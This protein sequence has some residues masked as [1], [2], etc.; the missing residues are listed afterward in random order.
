MTWMFD[1]QHFSSVLFSY[2]PSFDAGWDGVLGSSSSSTRVLPSFSTRAPLFVWPVFPS[3]HRISKLAIHI[4]LHLDRVHSLATS[5]VR[6]LPMNIGSFYS[7]PT[8]I[9][10]DIIIMSYNSNLLVQLA[11]NWPLELVSSYSWNLGQTSVLRWNTLCI[12][13]HYFS[14]PNISL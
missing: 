3:L 4:H 10:L 6:P 11:M 8:N 9:L 7:S 14:M 12:L 1:P 2:S 13:A 5:C